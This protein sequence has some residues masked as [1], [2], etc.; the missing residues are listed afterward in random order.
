MKGAYIVG[1]VWHFVILEKLG[2]NKYQYFISK[3]FNAT[4]IEDLKSIYQ[5]LLFVK[6]EIIE[7][8]KE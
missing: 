4:N 5:N 7:I 3:L 2:P 1:A 6:N 8:T